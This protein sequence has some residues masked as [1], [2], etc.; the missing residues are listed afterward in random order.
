MGAHTESAD[1]HAVDCIEGQQ[2]AVSAI[3]LPGVACLTQTSIGSTVRRDDAPTEAA[4]R[5]SKNDCS[6][7]RSP[8]AI[9]VRCLEQLDRVL[10]WTAKHG[11]WA[12]ITA[13]ASLAAGEARPGYATRT[14]F[15]T[16]ELQ[17]SFLR[18]WS[19][20]AARCKHFDF[21]AGYEVLSE[22]RVKPDKVPDD[23]VRSFYTSACTAVL[24]AD[25]RTPCII[26]AAPFYDRSRLE[27][28]VLSGFHNQIIY[29]FNF[30]VPRA[31]V[32]ASNKLANQYP[33]RLRCCDALSHAKC[34]AQWEHGCCDRMVQI[35]AAF[36]EQE[37]KAPLAFSQSRAVPIFLDQWGVSYNSGPGR[38]QY[39]SDML[40][41]LQVTHRVPMY[42]AGA[43]S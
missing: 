19:T 28:V 11:L 8:T 20:V 15:D 14:V 39:V 40:E 24:R 1:G 9:S 6:E 36:L 4:G 25:P 33:T 37:L 43:A 42:V 23:V 27:S 17:A 38:L 26:G 12:I 18:M 32:D 5:N 2:S 30:F 34:C 7:T 3:Q 13:R 10:S 22:P 21:V 29:N 35:D 16:P 41:L 31:Y